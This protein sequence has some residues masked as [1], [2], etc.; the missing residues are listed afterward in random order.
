MRDD[1]VVHTLV[2]GRSAPNRAIPRPL[3][4]AIR[5]G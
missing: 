2:I 4:G 5:G 1:L 3:A